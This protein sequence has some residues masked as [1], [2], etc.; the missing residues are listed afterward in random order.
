EASREIK[1]EAGDAA[2][3]RTVG[4]RRAW[5]R[6]SAQQVDQRGGKFPYPR[7]LV[8]QQGQWQLAA[9]DR[10]QRDDVVH[11]D[12]LREGFRAEHVTRGVDGDDA[13]LAVGADFVRLQHALA[14]GGGGMG[15][16]AWPGKAGAGA[17]GLQRAR[18]LYAAILADRDQSAEA[19]HL[20]QVAGAAGDGTGGRR[21]HGELT[22]LRLIKL[23]VQ[24][25][26]R[27]ALDPGQACRA[28]G[29]C[30]RPKPKT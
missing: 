22:V 8:A 16:F 14:H 4:E 11:E 15:R 19:A 1:D 23:I 21:C 2:A 17:Q 30:P 29:R 27:L 9:Y 3:H 6:T 7:I 5:H 25:A 26:S 13:L 12:A 24:W 18:A 10:L 28:A 20:I